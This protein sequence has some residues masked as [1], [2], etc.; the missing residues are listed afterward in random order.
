MNKPQNIPELLDWL[1]INCYAENYA[2][3]K[4]QIYEGYGLKFDGKGYLCYYPERGMQQDLHFF[5]Q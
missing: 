4:I 3:G 5:A 2:I 1:R